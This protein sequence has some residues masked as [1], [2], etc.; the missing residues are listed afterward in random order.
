M[1]VGSLV[2]L[3]LGLVADVWSTSC[4]L[5]RGKKVERNPIFG[6]HPT[7]KRIAVIMVVFTGAL[8]AIAQWLHPSDVAPLALIL[9]AIHLACAVIN[10]GSYRRAWGRWP[11]Q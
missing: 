8:V 9:A 2:I 7:R 3:L 1:L 6:A 4:N 5:C 11:W 10:A